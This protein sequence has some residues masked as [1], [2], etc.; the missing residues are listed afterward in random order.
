MTLVTLT[1]ALRACGFELETRLRRLDD[2][3]AHDWSLV[4]RNLEL[5]PRQRLDQVA[6]AANLV[7]GGRAAMAKRN[8]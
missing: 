4:R 2:G 7:L 3:E 8:G 6:A 1:R 5:T